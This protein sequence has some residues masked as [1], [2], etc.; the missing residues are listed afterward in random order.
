MRLRNRQR[1]LPN[2]IS[3]YDPATKYQ[4]PLHSTFTAQ[5][6]GTIAA[7]VANPGVT[8]QFNLATDREAVEREVDYYLCTVAQ[9]Q[10]WNDFV[11]HTRQAVDGG[12]PNQA[13]FHRPGQFNATPNQNR[14]PPAFVRKLQNVAG[15]SE[16]LV[17]WLAS[18]AEAVPIV[19]AEKRAAICVKCP[20][21]GHG[22]L[23]QIFTLPV[24]AA[25]RGALNLRREMR[26]ETKSDDKLGT[27]EACDCPLK[28][29]VH[30]PI[31][32]IWTGLSDQQK[33]SLD[34]G[35]WIPPEYK[36]QAP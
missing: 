19:L 14:Q 8:K 35:C 1:P 31:D 10:G 6:D 36:Q 11:D 25:I 5:V 4:A 32:R 23:E 27:C 28:L 30:L 22:G 34:P 15:G 2:G 20:L 7:R 13:P 29:K 16:V 3:F 21:N 26:L 17:D 9:R 12:L 18:G 33:A 24:A